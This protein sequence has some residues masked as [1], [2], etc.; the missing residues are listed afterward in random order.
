M[1]RHKH[2]EFPEVEQ[3]RHIE[4]P[5]QNR[6]AT[7]SK[8]R[9]K[10]KITAVF[11]ILCRLIVLCYRP[12]H[13]TLRTAPSCTGTYHTLV[14]MYMYHMGPFR[15]ARPSSTGH[16][17]PTSLSVPR[18]VGGPKCPPSIPGGQNVPPLAPPGAKVPRRSG[19]FPPGSFWPTR[20]AGSPPVQGTGTP[21]VSPRPLRS[22]QSLAIGAVPPCPRPVGRCWGRARG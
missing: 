5:F 7:I 9:V 22:L 13:P 15:P 1:E 2:I 6:E 19:G 16:S 11:G 12:T 14:Y 18:A 21:P 4:F 3:H 20:G 10:G 17:G 8:S